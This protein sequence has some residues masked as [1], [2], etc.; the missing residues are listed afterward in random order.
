[1]PSGSSR[2]EEKYSLLREETEREPYG[3]D[4][5]QASLADHES[6]T[7]KVKNH[8]PWQS[9]APAWKLWC[10]FVPLALIVSV[11]SWLAFF[12]SCEPCRNLDMSGYVCAPN[13]ALPKIARDRECEFDTM[14]FKWWPKEPMMH[15]D[16]IA[17]VKDFHSEGPWH[18][19]Y[20]KGGKHEIPPTTE[21]LTAGWVSRKEHTYHC[22]YTLR[23]THLWITL[24]YDPPFNYS[25]TVHCTKYLMDTILENPPEDFEELSVHGTPWPEHPDIVSAPYQGTF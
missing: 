24:G 19:Y 9:I 22:M 12:P 18:R 10:L 17:L 23:Q 25:H 4:T 11:L 3:E 13:G 15:K 5:S 21:V 14:S 20:D 16:N 7:I 1:M 8:L 2:R 6:G